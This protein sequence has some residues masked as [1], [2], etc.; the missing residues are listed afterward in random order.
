MNRIIYES[1]LYYAYDEFQLLDGEH[2][3]MFIKA[4]NTKFKYNHSASDLAKRRLGIYGESLLYAIL[5]QLYNVNTLVSRGY[6]YDIQK[7]SE[8]TGYDSFQ[9]IQR[10]NEIEL[11]FGETK[12]YEDGIAAID[13][14][15]SNIEKA[16]SDDYLVNTNFTTILQKKGNIIDKE[17]KLY[18]ILDK[19]DKCIIDSLED[20]LRDNQIKLVY[21]VLVTF[22]TIGNDYNETIKTAI[23]HINDKYSH[24]KFDKISIEYSIFFILM[25]IEDVKKSK[26]TIIEWIDKKEPLML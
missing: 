23:K 3:K 20:E 26:E 22:N 1:I 16:I 19:W 14:V 10:E 25:P 18:K 12:F 11:W 6:F 2:Q 7:K 8:V 13:K 5:H 24:L 9:L 21:P 15:F 4:F 17:S